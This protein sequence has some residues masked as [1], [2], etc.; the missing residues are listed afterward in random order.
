[1]IKLIRQNLKRIKNFVLAHAIS[2]K[3][4]DYFDKA[5]IKTYTEK[6]SVK[7][8]VLSLIKNPLYVEKDAEGQRPEI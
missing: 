2:K 7:S 4:L 5:R 1:M 3:K 6:F 8:M